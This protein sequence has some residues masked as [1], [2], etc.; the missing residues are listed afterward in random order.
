MTSQDPRPT[1]NGTLFLDR[2]PAVLTADLGATQGAAASAYLQTTLTP[3]N[4]RK[5]SASWGRCS[6]GWGFR[7][8]TNVKAGDPCSTI[9]LLNG[10]TTPQQ[11]VANDY[12]MCRC[13]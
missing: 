5:W 3:T 8:A 1:G 13:N 9:E 12:L 4:V 6:S 7:G 11:V 10:Q 2:E